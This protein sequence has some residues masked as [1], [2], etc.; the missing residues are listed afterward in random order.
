M[1]AEYGRWQEAYVRVFLQLEDEGALRPGIDAEAVGVAFAT[2]ADGLVWQQSL[3]PT[4]DTERM[5]WAIL[6]PQLAESAELNDGGPPLPSRAKS[7]PEE[8]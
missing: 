2:A 1:A 7:R 5:M 4:L 6:A 3:N 8:S